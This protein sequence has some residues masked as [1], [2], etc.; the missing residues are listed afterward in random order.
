MQSLYINYFRLFSRHLRQIPR[1]K[2]RDHD[3]IFCCAAAISVRRRCSGDLTPIGG[4]AGMIFRGISMD[5]NPYE[6]ADEALLDEVIRQAEARLSAQLTC[7]L[8]ADQRA[9]NFASILASLA[10]ALFAAAI[11]IAD[12]QQPMAIVAVIVSLLIAGASGL[13]IWGARPVYFHFVGNNPA[14][15]IEDINKHRSLNNIKSEINLHYDDMIKDNQKKMEKNAIL[16][17]TGTLTIALSFLIGVS[18]T[19]GILIS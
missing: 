18:I 3:L 19:A 17:K 9:V 2:G 12:S 16:F 5:T 11:N 15:F 8:A 14:S 13:I 1:Q 7:A 6:S 4:L 10:V